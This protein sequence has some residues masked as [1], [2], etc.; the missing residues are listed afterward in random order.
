VLALRGWHFRGREK[1]GLMGGLCLVL[2]FGA[3]LE[4]R[5]ALRRE[6]MTDLGVFSCASWAIWSGENLYNITDWRGWHYVYPPALAILFAPLEHPP[7]E[8]LPA[9]APGEKRIEANTPWGYEVPGRRFY[10]LRRQNARFFG[11]VAI[12]HFLSVGFC[13]FA[14]HAVACVLERRKLGEPP[15]EEKGTHCANRDTGRAKVGLDRLRI[16]KKEL[17]A[18]GRRRGILRWG[19]AAS[20]F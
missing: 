12:W 8:P 17:T 1:T 19:W 16:L 7:P 14:A 13:L 2:A 6:P 18:P 20:G 11:I 15:P 5:T 4:Q 3:N 10:G 9:L